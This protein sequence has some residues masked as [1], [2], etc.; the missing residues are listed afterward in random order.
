MIMTDIENQTAN[1]AM[2]IDN[3]IPLT[4]LFSSAGAV[5][6]LLFSLLWTVAGQSNKLDQLI[7]QAEKNERRNVERDIKFESVIRDGYESK[8]LVDLLTL[9]IEALE[10]THYK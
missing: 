10:K 2:V 1:Q 4:W 8:R 6:L 3:K 5:L 7:I 9:R